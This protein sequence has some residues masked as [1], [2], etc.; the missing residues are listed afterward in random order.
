MAESR[1][2]EK[3]SP[4]PRSAEALKRRAR[5]D[6]RVDAPFYLMCVCDLE[7]SHCVEDEINEVYNSYTRVLRVALPGIH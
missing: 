2:R 7:H 6:S 1:A 4:R 3:S 5:R